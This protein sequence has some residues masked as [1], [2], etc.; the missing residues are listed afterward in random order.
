MWQPGQQMKLG[1]LPSGGQPAGTLVAQVTLTAVLT[2]PYP[3]VHAAGLGGP[4]HSR[5]VATA[6][7]IQ[8]STVSLSGP[9]S[10]LTIPRGAAPGYY[11][12]WTTAATKTMSEG[13][14]SAVAVG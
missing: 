9:V 7:I 12:L 1:W 10:V 3:T 14:G 6:P 13:G 8:V 5:T 4:G 11:N 2:G